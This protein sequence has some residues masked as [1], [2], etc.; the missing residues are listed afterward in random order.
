MVNGA[1]YYQ[2]KTPTTFLTDFDISY[3]VTE[4]VS[5]TVGASNLT[6]Q[7]P[8]VQGV[9]TNGQPLDSGTQ[10]S[11]PRSQSP[12]GINGGFYFGRVTFNW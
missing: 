6:N 11:Q 5:M 12:Y 1:N 2:I 7:S 4:H 8:P 10:Y 9:Q 3:A